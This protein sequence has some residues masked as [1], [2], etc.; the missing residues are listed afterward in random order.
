MAATPGYL[1]YV[2]VGTAPS[3]TNKISDVTDIAMPWKVAPYDTS[4]MNG[5]NN[6]WETTIPGL[7]SGQVTIKC[8]YVPGDT[9]G[10][11]VMTTNFVSKT[12]LYFVASPNGTNTATFS[13]YVT[14]YQPHSPVNN[15]SDVTYVVKVNGAPTFA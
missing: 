12:L 6:G 8:N 10:Q 13:G 2:Q 14:D 5:T 7:G 3:P 15:K 9:N 11:L 4:S 1:G